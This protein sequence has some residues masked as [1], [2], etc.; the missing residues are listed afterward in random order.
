MEK[1]T[2]LLDAC[3]RGGWL[4]LAVNTKQSSDLFSEDFWDKFDF[5]SH[6]DA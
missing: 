5:R 6:L 4:L 2:W 3:F 1:Q